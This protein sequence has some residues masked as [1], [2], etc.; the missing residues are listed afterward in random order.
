MNTIRKASYILACTLV[1]AFVLVACSSDDAAQVI[2]D[3]FVSVS[4]TVKD[5]NGTAAVEDVV[6]ECVYSSPGDPLNPVTNTD[7]N[8]HFSLQ[9]LDNTP[10]SL[11]ATKNS[12]ASINTAKAALTATVTVDDVDILTVVQAQATIDKAFGLTTELLA[13]K[14]WLVVDVVDA[15]GNDVSGKTISTSLAFPPTDEIYTNCDGNDSGGTE[16]TGPCPVDRQ[17][18]MYIAYFNAPAEISITVEGQKQTA[19]IR[20]GEITVL[21]YVIV[22][23]E[24]VTVSGIVS[25]FT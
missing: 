22:A 8:G 7:N 12:F 24:F 6:V 25:N 23:N 3:E 15:S 20:M 9:V 5:F 14:A 2:A 19:P 10:V 11:R 21:K 18:P 13:D 1:F 16:T 4:G 17:A